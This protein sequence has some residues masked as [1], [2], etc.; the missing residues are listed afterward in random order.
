MGSKVAVIGAGSWGTT[1]AAIVATRTEAVLWARRP[2]LAAEINECRQNTTYLGDARLPESL[3]ATS[4]IAE[5]VEGASVVVMAVPSHGFRE[6]LSSALEAMASGTPVLSLAKG[7]EQE[8]LLRMTEV[9]GEVCPASPAGVLTGPNLASEVMD[10]QPAATVVAF[11]DEHLAR[12]LQGLF[13]TET[14]RVY[15]NTDVVGCEIAGAVK[16]V[17]AIATGMA[18]GLGFG[19]NTRAAVITRSLAEVARLGTALGGD[20][21]TFGGLAGLG[22]LVATCTSTKSRNFTV[23]LEL[24]AGRSMDEIVAGMKMVAEGIK[25]SRPV[26]QLAGR[27]GLEMP[28]AEQVVAVL[29]EGKAPAATIASLMRRS[30]KPELQGLRSEP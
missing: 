22:D 24:A 21:L 2:D 19:D 1:V 29:Y 5:A 28:I 7:L 16:N 15:T 18:V 20:P 4:S 3:R 8:T 11:A 6:V 30:A 10:G 9:A 27:L 23:G 13:S 25:S 17:M 14:L 12:E 26:V